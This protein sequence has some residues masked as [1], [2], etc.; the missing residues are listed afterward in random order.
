MSQANVELV[1]TVWDAFLR[2]DFDQALSGFHSDVE[3]DGTN[4]PDGNISHGHEAILD[5]IARWAEQWESWTVELGEFLDAGDD[6]VVFFHERG[7]SKSGIDM[8]ERHAEIYTVKAGTIVRRRGFSDTNEA[9]EA[10][11]LQE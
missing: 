3:W 5:H 10:A 6:V 8:D 2:G 7:R 4:L 1:R 9:L 11:G